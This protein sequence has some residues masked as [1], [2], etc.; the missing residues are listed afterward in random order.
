M[1]THGSL[2]KLTTKNNNI[3]K[4][5]VLRQCLPAIFHRCPDCPF[6]TVCGHHLWKEKKEKKGGGE[7]KKRK[8]GEKGKKKKEQ[9]NKKNKKGKGGKKAK[10]PKKRKGKMW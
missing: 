4:I 9:R 5:W 3:K 8:K 7:K 1:R 6:A 10:R 2:N